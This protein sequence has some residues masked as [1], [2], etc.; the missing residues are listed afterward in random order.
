MEMVHPDDR[1]Q[2]SDL[3]MRAYLSNQSQ[4]VDYRITR[5]DGSISLTN[6]KLIPLPAEDSKKIV[7]V[8][9]RI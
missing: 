9:R 2:L 4:E 1:R 7:L 6:G 5:P 3:I 8:Y